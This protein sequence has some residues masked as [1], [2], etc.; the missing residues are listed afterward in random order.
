MEDF[1][2]DYE[3]DFDDFHHSVDKIKK[4]KTISKMDMVDFIYND[5]SSDTQ[6][7]LLPYL[8]LSYPTLKPY[9]NSKRIKRLS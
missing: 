6:L 9:A 7:Y 8:D 1:E 5:N 2:D 4:E 3:D